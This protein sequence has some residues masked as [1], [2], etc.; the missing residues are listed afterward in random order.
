MSHTDNAD[1]ITLPPG[2]GSSADIKKRFS[3][4]AERRDLWRSILSDMYDF[5]IPNR[6]TFNFH[7]P[8]QR[9]SRHI[10]DSTAPEAVSTFVSVMIGSLTPD[11]TKWMKYQAGA[12][13]PKE[14]QKKVNELLEDQTDIFF[15]YLNLSDFQSQ[16]FTSHQDMSIST[17]CLLIEEGNDLDEPLIKFTAIPLAELYLEPTSM[18]KVH[19]FFRKHSIKAQELESKFPEAKISKELRQK[20]DKEP[21]SDLEIVD[22]SQ[23]FNFKDKTY[24]QI[25]MWKDEI[26]FHQSYGDSP[27][28]I[29]YR[30]SKVANETYGRGPADMAMADIR[31]VNKVKEFTLKQAALDISPPMMGVSDGVFNPHNVVVHPGTI[32]A[33]ASLAN[34]PPLAAVDFGG[35]LDLGAFVIQDLQ[36]NIRKAFLADPLGDV[37]DPVQS[38][39]FNLI[40]QQ[41]IVKKRGANLGRLRSEFIEPVVTRVTQILVKSGKLSEGVTV[42][43]RKVTMK[44]DSPLASAEAQENVSNMSLYLNLV[45]QLPEDIAILGAPLEAVPNFL[46]KN[47]NLPEEMSRSKEDIDKAK[48]ILLTQAAEAA[49]EQPGQQQAPAG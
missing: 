15:K 1:S 46:Q 18:A 35:R 6:E 49:N 2:L 7:S 32:M 25:V 30:W 26:I 43:G 42:D 11:S 38:A 28:G 8:G 41:E 45:N 21:T 13:I 17:G 37:N 33:V 27:P 5:C 10:F 9:K 39:T 24:H 44:M 3:K 4:A 22:G 47:L 23:V 19:T 16:I 48:Q 40:K 14:E 20:I 31:T 29:I 12:D 34:G 36:E